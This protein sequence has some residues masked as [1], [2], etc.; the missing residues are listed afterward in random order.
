MSV[1][2]LFIE[3][4]G[5]PCL[6]SGGGSKAFQISRQ[7]LEA[8]AELSVWHPA[9]SQEF[10]VLQKR[11][12]KKLH[13]IHGEL[14]ETMLLHIIKGNQAPS[15]AVFASESQALDEAN[16]ALC[17]EADIWCH[18]CKD[19]EQSLNFSRTASYGPLMLAFAKGE[20]PELAEVW[21]TLLERQI[22][23]AWAEGAEAFAQFRRS[24]QMRGITAEAR[25]DH[26]R[27]LASLMVETG[28][29]FQEALRILGKRLR[30][31]DAQGSL[32]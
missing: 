19:E 32:V 30:K 29:D 21:M 16:A 12:A 24:E 25:A 20:V 15:L 13:L 26:L 3:F 9:F 17:K 28:G 27:E 4:E 2:A 31:R 10:D 1:L 22:P 5:R 23:A 11:F 14:T 7:L 6:V 8:G 18:V